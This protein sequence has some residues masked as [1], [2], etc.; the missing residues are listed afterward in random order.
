MIPKSRL[1]LPVAVFAV[2]LPALP[3]RA[4]EHTFRYD[5]KQATKVEIAGEF[6]N[7]TAVPMAR[8]ND[9]I[10]TATINLPEGEYGYKFLV[11]GENWVFDPSTPSRKTVEG[12]ENSSVLVNGDAVAPVS[13]PAPAPDAGG[14]GTP[15]PQEWTFTYTDPQAQAV[16]V[17]G[18]FNGWNTEANPLSRNDE[19][20]WTAVVHLEPGETTYKFI[21]DGE[22]K[23]DPANGKHAEDGQGGANSV[24]DIEAPAH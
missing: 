14:A 12:E 11:N 9:G 16:Y 17:T 22:W 3:C 18:S 10:W 5:D 15:G 8:G 2:M 20:V 1:L 7:W 19:G 23:T 13:T 6:N 24:I 4:G 21:V